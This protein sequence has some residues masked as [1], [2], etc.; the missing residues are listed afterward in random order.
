M[1]ELTVLRDDPFLRG[2]GDYPFR[3]EPTH[4]NQDQNHDKNYTKDAGWSGSPGSAI[5]PSWKGSYEQED[6]NDEQ[7]CS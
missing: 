1:F 5:P 4:Q 7:N 6:Q 3:L 2:I